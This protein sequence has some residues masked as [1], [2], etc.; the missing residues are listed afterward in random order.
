M[1]K[2]TLKYLILLPIIIFCMMT[3]VLR[4]FKIKPY[5]VIS[6]SMAP[7]VARNAFVYVKPISYDEDLAVGDIVLIK[8]NGLPL[9][10]RIVE[11]DNTNITTKGDSNQVN[12]QVI[13]REKIEGKMLFSIPIIGFF[14]RTIYPLIITLL[15]IV[16]FV[17]LKQLKSEIKKN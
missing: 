16:S 12:D 4:L 3:L 17:V 14:F 15:I 5:V 6:D 10:H 11:I 1:F 7:T 9:M 13:G 8:T 2:T